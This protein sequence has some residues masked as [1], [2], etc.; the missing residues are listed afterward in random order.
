L[1]LNIQHIA[2]IHGG[3]AALLLIFSALFYISPNQRYETRRLISIFLVLTLAQG[4][5]GYI[6]YIK[7]VPELLVGS[8]LLGSTLVW[9]AAWRIRLS[10]IRKPA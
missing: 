6:Q 4:V 7:G 5:I 3:I 2:Y 1:R 10:V 9:I 8:H